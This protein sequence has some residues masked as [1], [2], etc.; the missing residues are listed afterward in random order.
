MYNLYRVIH[1]SIV[2]TTDY[3]SWEINYSSPLRII[4]VFDSRSI[5]SK[6]QSHNDCPTFFSF[7]FDCEK[8]YLW[9]RLPEGEQT[10]LASSQRRVPQGYRHLG[11]LSDSYRPKLTIPS[12][13]LPRQ[14][15]L[16]GVATRWC[17][18][19]TPPSLGSFRSAVIL[20]LVLFISSSFSQSLRL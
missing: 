2:Q 7:R 18:T 12:L 20:P 9:G 19:S 16:G 13:L 11:I 3:F 8:S 15:W 6:S 4:Y 17:P 1:S 14:R 5:N 10:V